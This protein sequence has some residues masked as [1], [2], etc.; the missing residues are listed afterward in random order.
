[1]PQVSGM[2]TRSLSKNAT[3]V[4]PR[5]AA[6]WLASSGGSMRAAFRASQLIRAIPA[7]RCPATAAMPTNQSRVSHGSWRGAGLGAGSIAIPGITTTEL[8]AGARL[9]M[10]A[11]VIGGGWNFSAGISRDNTGSASRLT[12]ARI[13]RNLREEAGARRRAKLTAK[14]ARRIKL[15]LRARLNNSALAGFISNLLSTWPGR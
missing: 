3:R 15:A 5:V 7:A 8:A 1:M 13:Q 14:A 9:K 2:A 4:T 10:L 12:A 6:S 11:Y